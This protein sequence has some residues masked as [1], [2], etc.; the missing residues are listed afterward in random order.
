MID[1][2]Q[3]SDGATSI[4]AETCDFETSSCIWR[5]DEAAQWKWSRRK[6]DE[7]YTPGIEVDHRGGNGSE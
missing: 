5:V 1:R 4:P 7:A 6:I 3:S 2:A